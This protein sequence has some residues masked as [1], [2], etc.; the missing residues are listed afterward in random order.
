MTR[1]WQLLTDAHLEPGGQHTDPLR[2]LY[3]TDCQNFDLGLN[4]ND[5][6]QVLPR[7]CSD[8]TPLGFLEFPDTPRDAGDVLDNGGLESHG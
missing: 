4:F 1:Q 6:E 5:D 2:C 3:L 7:G 8:R